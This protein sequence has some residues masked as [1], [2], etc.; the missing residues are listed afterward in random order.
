TYA[1]NHDASF[2]SAFGGE[3]T[4][5]V[6]R[7]FKNFNADE[8]DPES[9]IFAPTD[10]YLKDITNAGTKVFYRLGA[11]IEHDF[12]YGTYPPASFEKWAKICEHII[13]HYNEGWAEGFNYNIEY[14]EIWNEP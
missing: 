12:K 7:I 2:Y 11:S 13:S 10:K 8:N 1:R 14:W 4:V 9:Y 3:H 6:H 5:D